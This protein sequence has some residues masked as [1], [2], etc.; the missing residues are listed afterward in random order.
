[1]YNWNH[2]TNASGFIDFGNLKGN[3]KE[4]VGLVI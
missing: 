3:G 1:M 4:S 2:E